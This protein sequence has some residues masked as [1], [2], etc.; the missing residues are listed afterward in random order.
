MSQPSPISASWF[1][2]DWVRMENTSISVEN[3]NN[4]LRAYCFKNLGFKIL[5]RCVW[6]LQCVLQCY[7]WLCFFCSLT[8]D[9]YWVWACTQSWEN[10]SSDAICSMATDIYMLLSHLR[11]EV[12]HSTWVSW[13]EKG[14]WGL[15]SRARF[16]PQL[17]CDTLVPHSNILVW[18]ILPTLI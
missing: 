2:G 7:N 6:W 8:S 14:S 17:F 11:Y 18:S 1:S 4:I 5:V 3:K 10:L 9:P 13:E 12:I 15:D 16:Q